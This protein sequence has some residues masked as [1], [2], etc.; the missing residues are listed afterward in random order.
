MTDYTITTDFGAKDSLPSGNAAKVIKGSEFTTEFTNIKTAVNSKADTAG[1]TFT[2][3]VTF[4]DAVTLNA[5]VTFDT[6]T[7]FVDVSE[8]RVGIGNVAPA[9]ALDVTGVI[10]TDGLTSSAGIDITGTV[11]ASGLTVD[12]NTLHVDATNDRVGIGTT[13]PLKDLNVSNTTGSSEIMISTS[14]TG[15]GSLEFGDVTSGAVAR[16]FLKYNHSDNS[17][18][19]GSAQTER[20]R[21]D[22]SGNVGIGTSSPSATLDVA[23]IAKISGTEDEQL[24]LNSTDDGPVYMAFERSNDRHAYLGFGG[25]SDHFNIINEESSGALTLGTN[26]S[27]RMRI[28]S[29]GKVGIG[30]TSPANTLTVGAL[31]ASSIYA[32]AT[33]GIKC[34]TNHK[35]LILQENSGAEQWSMGVNANG[36]LNFYDSAVTDP[37]V[38]FQD[39]SGY[40]GIGTSSPSKAFHVKGNDA[41]ILIQDS[42]TSYALQE[43]GVI[44]T[45]SATDGTP[46]TDVQRKVRLNGDALTF[47]RGPSDTEH[48]R[49]DSSGKV[50]I[51]TSSPSSP[52]HI[53]NSGTASGSL[54]EGITLTNNSGSTNNR[55]PAITWD[56]GAAG[57]PTFAAIDTS[58][59]SGTG[60]NLLFH[61]ASTAGSL[62]ERMR[63]D[64]SGNLLVGKTS[65]GSTIEGAE[66][67]N[68]GS[69]FAVRN[70]NPAGAFDRKTTDGDVVQFRKDGTTVGSIGTRAAFLN[71]GSGDTGLLFNSTS[72][73]IQPE[74]T[75]GGAR[76]AAIDIGGSSTRFKDLYRSGSTYSTSDRNKKQDIRDLTD[77][78]ARVALVA[79]GSL[80]AFR[81]IDT[82]EAEGDDA[83]IHFGIIAQD[84][85]AAFEAEGLNADSYQ[86][87]KTSTYTDDDGVEQTTYSVCYENLLAFIISA[88]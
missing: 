24:V 59:S 22:S 73:R 46:R 44:L 8:N 82:V 40:V 81:Y 72:D 31:E 87:L 4:D 19:F 69:I 34:D 14:D 68:S 83:N 35:G 45:C 74:S 70:S 78:E 88:I 76:D 79:K 80:K 51:G 30:T 32:D 84:L 43:S 77:A 49:I 3:A 75:T 48:M 42:Q 6:D 16:G 62:T 26:G 9:T 27:E 12:T 15:T 41:S 28:D 53:F 21:I 20:M 17:L 71:I 47:T 85:K 37:L 11:T 52:L 33:V 1:D 67:N 63:I 29:S 55:L 60:G 39:N 61:T 38:T 2:G 36:D 13:S 86:V 65:S 18:Q 56:Y 57:T 50:G 5:D 10:T 58:R 66:L 25:S 54:S 7:M 23:G 64:T